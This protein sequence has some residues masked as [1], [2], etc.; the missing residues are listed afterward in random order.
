M[1]ERNVT[2][3]NPTPLTTP[4]VWAWGGV[5]LTVTTWLTAVIAL[6]H[7]LGSLFT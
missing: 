5:V 1:T 2:Q 3:Q 4:L 6:F 7:S